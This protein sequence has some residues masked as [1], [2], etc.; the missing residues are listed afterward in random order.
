MSRAF[1][2]PYSGG[3]DGVDMVVRPTILRPREPIL[4]P[5]SG[6]RF[7]RRAAERWPRSGPQAASR[8]D[9]EAQAAGAD[10]GPDPRELVRDHA[11]L[12]ALVAPTD[13]LRPFG[14]RANDSKPEPRQRP[15]AR[16]TGGRRVVTTERT[17]PG[18]RPGSPYAANPSS[19]R[20]ICGL[21]ACVQIDRAITCVNVTPKT[22]KSNV[23]LWSNG[24]LL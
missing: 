5:A 6:P 2:P 7:R 8:R 19:I 24:G 12:A 17:S 16:D 1:E 20:S 13:R 23:S 22:E 4:P 15:L 21:L 10:D 11:Q 9:L 14:I 3:D 18:T